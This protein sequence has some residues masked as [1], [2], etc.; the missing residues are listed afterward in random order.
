LTGGIG[1][2]KS[3]VSELLAKRGAVIVDAD[4][5]VREIQQPGGRAYDGIVARFG[6]GIVLADGSIDRPALAAI[7]F[8]DDAVR[9]EL[10]ALTWPH[11]GAVMAERMAAAGPDDIV[12]LDI[13]LLAE[14]G[15]TRYNMG[16]VVVV[17]CPPEVALDR[18]VTQRGMERDDA[19]RRMAAQ[20]TREQRLALADF[21]ID[22]SGDRD[23]LL[24]EV[25]RA[26]TWMS[27]LEPPPPTAN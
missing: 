3:T 17:D 1:S 15:R 6:P 19:Q 7:V 9:G 20:A 2:G 4:A 25:D 11:V 12:I 24:P 8:G 5:I 23:A 21:V 10:N 26:W 13:P 14:G 18:L 27:N 16:G 22:N